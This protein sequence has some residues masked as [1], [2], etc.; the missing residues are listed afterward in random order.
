MPAAQCGG[1]RFLSG[2]APFA[3]AIA[4]H[5][6]IER[7]P[8]HFGGEPAS[9]AESRQVYTFRNVILNPVAVP[10]FLRVDLHAIELHGEVNVV[11]SGH[12]RHAALA[13]DLASLHHVAFVHINMAEVAVDRLQP[14]AMIDHD[15]V[16]VDAERRR[17]DNPAIIGRFHAHVL[18]DREI[19]SKVHLLID[20][21]P[22]VDV[23]P[24]V[25]EGRFRLG[26]RLPRERL[27]PQEPVRGLEAQIRKRLVIGTPHLV[28]DLH[29]T[30]HGIARAIRVKLADDLL[31]ERS[32]TCKSC[33]VYFGCSFLGNWNTIGLVTS[34]PAPLEA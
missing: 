32:L 14:V 19:V 9:V 11:A 17:I 28:I 34:F 6:M 26:M 1:C 16:A 15:A 3:L 7:H 24:H 22:L 30:R 25:G 12:S 13:H 2:G 10:P 20:L 27:R 21:L 31:H 18:R 4:A 5:G 33:T 23:V 29:K 8:A